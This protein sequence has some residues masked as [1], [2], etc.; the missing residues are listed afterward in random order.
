MYNIL[1]LYAIKLV[2]SYIVV[3]QLFLHFVF[4]P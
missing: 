3:L 1:D 2:V 4:E